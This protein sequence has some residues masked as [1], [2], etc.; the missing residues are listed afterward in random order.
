MSSVFRFKQFEINQDKCAMKVGTDGVLIGAWAETDNAKNILDIGAGTG[1][2]SLM[3]AQRTTAI[4]VAV[5]IDKNAFEQAKENFSNSKWNNRLYIYNQSIQ[6]FSK[7]TDKQYDLIISNPPYFSNAYRPENDARSFARHNVALS[8]ED[9]LEAVSVVISDSGK[10]A[11]VLPIEA[12]NFIE[13]ARNYDLYLVRKCTVLP[14]NSKPTKRLLLE[15]SKEK[16]VLKTENLVIEEEQRH[17]YSQDYINLTKEF[18]LK[19]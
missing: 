8:F 4:I 13:L 1:L 7:I 16:D 9:L 17:Q 3:L 19:M 15:F 12:E 18:Y 5:E 2:I 10:F 6:D 14:N 11:V